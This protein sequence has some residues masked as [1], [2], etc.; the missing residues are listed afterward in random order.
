MTSTLPSNPNSL[1][2]NAIWDKA[3]GDPFAEAPSNN[4]FVYI[5]S[6]SSSQKDEAI[7]GLSSIAFD[8]FHSFIFVSKQEQASLGVLR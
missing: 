4:G 2:S 1:N 6:I 5:D 8:C 7:K 3:M